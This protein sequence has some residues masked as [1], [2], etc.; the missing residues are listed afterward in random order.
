MPNSP[1]ALLAFA[2]CAA[3]FLMPPILSIFHGGGLWWAVAAVVVATGTLYALYRPNEI[4]YERKAKGQCLRCGYD[5]TGN[6]SGVCPEC[7]NDRS[8]E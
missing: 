7:G 8:R 1:R 5:L 3:A 2:V 6:V 4:L